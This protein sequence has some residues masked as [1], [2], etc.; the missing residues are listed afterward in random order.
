MLDLGQ[1][2]AREGSVDILTQL[3]DMV[4]GD[5]I[6]GPV[7]LI[8]EN[9]FRHVSCQALLEVVLLVVRL[10]P[11][12]GRAY[13]GPGNRAR[14]GRTAWA[15][16]RCAEE[17]QHMLR[18]FLHA[19]RAGGDLLLGGRGGKGQQLLRAQV[20]CRA[21]AA[22]MA[23]RRA[24]TGCQASSA[25]YGPPR[26]GLEAPLGRYGVVVQ[27]VPLIQQG[28]VCV[29]WQPRAAVAQTRRPGSAPAA[30]TNRSG[31]PAAR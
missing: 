13:P 9:I 14:P 29:R 16:S 24:S 31:R 15:G 3:I 5:A 17:A 12:P 10:H 27:A 25:S 7:G 23:C 6:A 20:Q 8:W 28:A 4:G 19:Q 26:G 1:D 21:A 30:G 2:D 22:R 18:R 11:R